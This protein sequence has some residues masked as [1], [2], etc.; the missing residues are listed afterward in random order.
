MPP[1]DRLR[2]DL[3]RVSETPEVCK[4]NS[5]LFDRLD[6]GLCYCAFVARSY[7]Y[8]QKQNVTKA[9][10]VFL[11]AAAEVEHGWSEA[12]QPA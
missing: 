3:K 11:L 8:L 10:K 1:L 5:D 6:L 2:K 12:N 4:T 9:R 7:R